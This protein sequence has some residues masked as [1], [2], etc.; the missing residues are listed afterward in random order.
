ME[1][2]SDYVR[3]RESQFECGVEAETELT[4]SSKSLLEMLAP[5][6]PESV[7]RSAAV[8]LAENIRKMTKVEYNVFC[9]D[10][11]YIEF[12]DRAENELDTDLGKIFLRLVFLC[13]YAKCFPVESFISGTH[14]LFYMILLEQPDKSIIDIGVF[15]LARIVSLQPCVLPPL[16]SVGLIDKLLNLPFSEASS[17]ILENSCEYDGDHIQQIIQALPKFLTSKDV[18]VLAGGVRLA[19]FAFIYLRQFESDLVEAKSSLFSCCA[20]FTRDTNLL[21]DYLKCLTLISDDFPTEMVPFLITIIETAESQKVAKRAVELLCMVRG[22]FEGA[23]NADALC[24]SLL[25]RTCNASFAEK[26]TYA[27]AISVFYKVPGPHDASVFRLMCE[28]LASYKGD[29]YAIPRIRCILDNVRVHGREVVEEIL[30][31]VLEDVSRILDDPDVDGELRDI[32]T[33]LSQLLSCV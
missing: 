1:S 5:G 21:E 11:P 26:R 16:M 23:I 15:L 29:N 17:Y 7:Q 30:D 25:S 14:F 2:V 13:C 19:S 3:E 12:L 4:K 9:R 20:N 10:F 33:V 31:E 18:S 8:A 22:K 32:V 6:S 28:F 24:V 27:S